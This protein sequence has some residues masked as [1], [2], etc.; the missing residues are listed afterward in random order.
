MKTI[1]E[2]SKETLQ[3]EAVLK[4]AKSGEFI[5]YQNLQHLS[6]VRMDERGKQFMR[7]A[8]KRLKL[9]YTVV[10]GKGIELSS[11]D[12]AIKIVATKVIRI[13]NSVKRAE[14]TTRNVTDKHYTEMKPE[15]QRNLNFLGAAFASIR[16]YSQSAKLF[17]KKQENKTI[18]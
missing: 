11:P 16:A 10:P 18:N 5:M 4:N 1:A 3:I 7:T 17:F 8:L 13:D 6:G 2:V 14:K 12:N 9:E 15:E